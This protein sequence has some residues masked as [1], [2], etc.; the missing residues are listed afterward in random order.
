MR[1]SV[2]MQGSKE[3]KAEGKGGRE[4]RVITPANLKAQIE[5][6]EH[7]THTLSSLYL[8]GGCKGRHSWYVQKRRQKAAYA[9]AMVTK[10]SNKLAHKVEECVGISF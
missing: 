3:I 8:Y 7:S 9:E 5:H 4:W 10:K 6:H 2:R 1:A